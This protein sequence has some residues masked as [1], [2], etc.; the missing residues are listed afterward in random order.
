VGKPVQ[1]GDLRHGGRRGA[2]GV[3]AHLIEEALVELA[4]LAEGCEVP[5]CAGHALEAAWLGDRYMIGIEDH[6]VFAAELARVLTKAA[7]RLATQ[8]RVE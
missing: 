5:D 1:L 8:L 7:E 3:A 4:A 6:R 2:G